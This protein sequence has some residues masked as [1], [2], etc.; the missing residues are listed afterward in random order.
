M[1]CVTITAT[2][3]NGA[4][5]VIADGSEPPG[6]NRSALRRHVEAMT[7]EEQRAWFAEQI[8]WFTRLLEPIAARWRY[9][10]AHRRPSFP[11]RAYADRRPRESRHGRRPT[12]TRGS[13]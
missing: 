4:T 11:S 8:E 13:P 7:P 10:Q 9:D 6:L 3:P 1:K 12:T 2:R 5:V